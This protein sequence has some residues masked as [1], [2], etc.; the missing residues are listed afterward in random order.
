MEVAQVVSIFH[1][2]LRT[3]HAETQGLRKQQNSITTGTSHE[4]MVNIDNIGHRDSWL[5]YPTNKAGS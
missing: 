1:A 4:I 3:N 5:Y 2:N